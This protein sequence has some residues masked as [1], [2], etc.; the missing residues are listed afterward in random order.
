M[1]AATLIGKW[2]YRS[3]LNNPAPTDGDPQKLADL[4]FAEAVFTFQ[5]PTSGTLKG[6]IDWQGGGL[7]L[8]RGQ[9]ARIRQVMGR[10][11][12]LSALGVPAPE[13]TDGSTITTAAW[14][15]PGRMA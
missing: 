1:P 5:L 8:K 14:P 15:I 3:F 13:R 4:L 11:W 12:K 6:A 9:Y 2:T 7:D 10:A